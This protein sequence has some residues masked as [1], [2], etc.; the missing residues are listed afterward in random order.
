LL[1]Q[2]LAR[3]WQLA[4]ALMLLIGFGANWLS[5]TVTADTNP[6]N[7]PLSTAD[8]AEYVVSDASG[9]GLADVKASLLRHS[10]KQVI[11][12]LANCQGLRYL[13]LRDFTV[14]CP[15]INPNGDSIPSLSNLLNQSRQVGTYAVLERIPYLPTSAPGIQIDEIKRPGNGPSLMIYDL[16]P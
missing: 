10:A 3:R 1:S 13:A 16:S 9:F 12:V 4:L 5:F 11:G 8:Y 6:V 2:R 15:T 7:T 14:T